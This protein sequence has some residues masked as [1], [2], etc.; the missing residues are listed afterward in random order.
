MD[1]FTILNFKSKIKKATLFFL[2]FTQLAFAKETLSVSFTQALFE[3]HP[4]NKEEG[5]DCE[6]SLCCVFQ[7]EGEWLREWLEYHKLIGIHHFYLYN[8]LS[9]DHFLEVISPYI[10][11]GEVELFDFPKKPLQVSD[12]PIIYNHA[13]AL[14][15]GRST[16]IAAI[17]TDEFIVPL[18]TK[19]LQAYLGSFPEGIGAIEINWQT[20][21]TSRIKRLRPGEL[22]I[23]KLI[24]RA[25][26]NAS[27]NLWHKSI[28]RP[29]AASHWVDA[30]S[31]SLTADYQIVRATLRGVDKVPENEAAIDQ[32]RIHHYIWRTEDFFYQVKLPR[33]AKWD[34]NIFHCQSPI[35]YLPV[36]N[37]VLDLTMHAFV[38]QLKEI[39][40][41]HS[42][43]ES[44]DE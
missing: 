24:L 23:E 25:P 33:I 44:K 5:R 15:K 41:N 9:T 37:T 18:K 38:P 22:L 36:T 30:H 2:L 11:S 13:L 26:I 16:W 21:G 4:L 39:M 6:I 12:Q 28:V 10:I 8:N 29:E 19:D 34:K 20:F 31:C 43:I 40:F 17:D 1:I 14:A 32:I 27:V 3:P 35:D 7:N 42:S